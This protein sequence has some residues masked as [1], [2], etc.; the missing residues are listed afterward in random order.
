MIPLCASRSARSHHPNRSKLLTV[1]TH[2]RRDRPE[3]LLRCMASVADALPTDAE[4]RVIECYADFAKAR[5]DATKLFSE[6]VAFVDDDDYISKESLELCVQAIQHTG[7]GCAFTNEVVV[8]VTGNELLANRSRRM[9]GGVSMHPRTI[10]HVAVIRTALVDERVLA[11]NSK[12]DMGICWFIKASAALRGGAVQVPID[13]AYWTKHTGQ[14][15]TNAS[16]RYDN[17]IREMGRSIR[18]AW[19]RSDGIIPLYEPKS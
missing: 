11:L 4:H 10:H 19:P 3:L 5:Y 15:T 7:A 16:G 18:E 14:L 1:V 9:Y 6:F 2:T 17:N 12:F 13:G 8:D